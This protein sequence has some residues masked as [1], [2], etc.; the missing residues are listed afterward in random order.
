MKP[1][2]NNGADNNADRGGEAAKNEA[3]NNDDRGGRWTGAT[4]MHGSNT[5]TD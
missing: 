1:K 3:D 4:Q 5:A 2:A